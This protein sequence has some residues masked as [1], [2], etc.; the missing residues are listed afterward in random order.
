[1]ASHEYGDKAVGKSLASRFR[2]HI[3]QLETE[4]KHAEE[5][6]NCLL[7][8]RRETFDHIVKSLSHQRES[9]LED[10]VGGE[11][12]NINCSWEAIIEHYDKAEKAA[13]FALH[14]AHVEY[15]EHLKVALAR[16][17][18]RLVALTDEHLAALESLEDRKYDWDRYAIKIPLPKEEP[19]WSQES[20]DSTV[21]EI[22][23]PAIESLGAM[24]HAAKKRKRDHGNDDNNHNDCDDSLTT[25]KD[26]MDE[27]GD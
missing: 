19:K 12:R 27:D 6:I 16:H 17:K 13:K 9:L 22:A 8:I 20:L 21:S 2:E 15:N 14:R 5:E 18:A 1:M 26:S 7:A 10:H 25:A 24:E 3:E 23:V 4:Q 11:A